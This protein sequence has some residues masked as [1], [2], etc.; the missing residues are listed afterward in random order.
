V[1]AEQGTRTRVLLIGGDARTLRSLRLFLD[2]LGVFEAVAVATGGA[3]FN[4][5]T[6]QPWAAVVMVDDLNDMLPE[7]VIAAAREAGVRAP[8][9]A[10]GGTDRG[11]THA[12][13]AAGVAEVVPLGAAPTPEVARALGRTIERGA[14]LE[15]IELLETELSQRRTVDEE[16][17]LYPSWRFDEDWRLEQARARRRI[18]DLAM[19][20]TTLESVP[21]LALL[22]DRDRIT[23]TR[24]AGR[25][26]RGAL[27][28]GD[29]A[30]HDGGGRFRILLVDVDSSGASD[31]AARISQALRQAFSGSPIPV[32][33]AVHLAD[34][35]EGTSA[36]SR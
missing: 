32:A 27:R 2:A 19:L 24:Q 9:L 34:A 6:R 21:D 4:A 18:G 36:H 7:Q 14:L 35:F 8:V 22:P 11:R 5:M 3:G 25:I 12:L 28:E 10:L 31:V 1:V 17:G 26:L 16:T 33:A 15:R 30:C 20:A 13:Y 23:L 29:I